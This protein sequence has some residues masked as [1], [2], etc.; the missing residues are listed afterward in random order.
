MTNHPQADV[1]HHV[2]I[3]MDGNGR[4]AAER[5]RPR[6]YGHHRGAERVREIVRAA[7]DIGIGVLTIYA[8]STE[9][10]RR[11]RYEVKVAD[12]P[13]PTLYRARGGRT[14]CRQRA[15]ALHR[16]ANDAAGEPAPADVDDGG[17]HR[18]RIPAC[19]CRS[20]FPMA[21]GRRSPRVCGRSPAR[22]RA[23]DLDP[24]AI[25]Q[26]AISATRSTRLACLIRTW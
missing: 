12:E 11:P 1:P 10:W 23:G 24:E 21:P 15:C 22:S 25:D 9:N 20:R 13:V 16:P 4:W 17:A 5:G 8:F 6:S 3:I 18:P 14:G 19:A 2:A 7:S 26:E